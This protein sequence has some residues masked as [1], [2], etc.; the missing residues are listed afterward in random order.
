MVFSQFFVAWAFQ[1]Q[2]SIERQGASPLQKIAKKCALLSICLPNRYYDIRIIYQ[3]WNMSQNNIQSSS[4][5]SSDPE[6]V[7]YESICTCKMCNHGSAR[8]CSKSGCKCCK[9]ENHSMIMN[10]MEGFYSTDK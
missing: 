9:K 5:I 10:G 1:W 2:C 4:R 8:D 6:Q 3:H 7:P